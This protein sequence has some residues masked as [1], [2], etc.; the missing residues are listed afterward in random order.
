MGTLCSMGEDGTRGPAQDEVADEALLQSR[1]QIL[2]CVNMLWDV[3]KGSS[4]YIVKL[5]HILGTH[6]YKTIL[7]YQSWSRYRSMDFVPF[8][9]TWPG[10]WGGGWGRL[11]CLT[12]APGGPVHVS[13]GFLSV[14]N[15]SS[16]CARLLDQAS[17]SSWQ[18]TDWTPPE[19]GDSELLA[20][21]HTETECTQLNLQDKCTNVMMLSVSVFISEFQLSSQ[22]TKG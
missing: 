17:G 3:K 13:A 4:T 18:T 8:Y 7:M 20:V 22:D 16:L 15:S 19:T 14:L 9:F 6:M 21:K 5:L 2:S 1:G 10:K 12:G 11:Q